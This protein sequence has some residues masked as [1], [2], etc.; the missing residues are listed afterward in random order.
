MAH[1]RSTLAETLLGIET[2]FP[3]ALSLKRPSSTLAE[4]LLGIETMQQLNLSHCI[5]RSTLAETLLGIET[6]LSTFRHPSKEVPLW[7]KPF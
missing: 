2:S 5:L 6:R 1:P 3:V 4:T 7:L